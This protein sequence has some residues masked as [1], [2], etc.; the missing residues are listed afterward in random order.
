MLE[1]EAHR[2]GT[3]V[4][5]NKPATQ[6]STLNDKD[7]FA[8][9]KAV[10]G[11]ASTFSHTAVPEGCST[12]EATW[13]EVELDGLPIDSVT[14]KNR[15]CNNEESKRCLCRLSETVVMLL[16]ENGD[17][18]DGTMTGDMCGEYEWSYQF[19]K[20]SRYCKVFDG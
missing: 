16:D 6:A 9:S 3:N 17:W 15:A 8:A 20:A 13:W 7:K 2:S 18:V 14:V 1:V 4:A 11:S 10:D 19:S 12:V 5:L